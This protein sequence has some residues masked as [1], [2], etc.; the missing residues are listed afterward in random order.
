MIIVS[1]YIKINIDQ[2]IKFNKEIKDFLAPSYVYVPFYK[3]YELLVKV[4]NDVIQL[5]E[6]EIKTED[7][8]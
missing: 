1:K 4:K 8:K 3:D 7:S 6:N 2:N 5:F